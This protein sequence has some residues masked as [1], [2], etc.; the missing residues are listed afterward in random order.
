MLKLEN[1]WK[2]HLNGELDKSYMVELKEFLADE[3]KAGKTIYPNDES[4]F[5]AFN[6]TPLD[7]VKVVIIGQDPYHGAAQ[8][9]GLSFSVQRGV[10][11]P[12]SLMNIYKELK[13]DINFE[14]PDHGELTKWAKQGVLLLNSSLTVEHAKAGSHR[15]KGW[16][17]FTDKV[18]EVLNTEKENLVFLLWGSPAQKKAGIVDIDKHLV[19]KSPHPSPLSAYRGFLGCKHFSQTNEYLKSVGKNEIDWSLS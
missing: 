4:I 16:E 6:T 8:A 12:P 19:L 18:I 14:L 9:H 1:S 13:D 3:A 17:I 15:K 2:K 7:D 11:I 10:K 5:N